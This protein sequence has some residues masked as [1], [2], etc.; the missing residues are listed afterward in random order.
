M[1]LPLRFANGDAPIQLK[2]KGVF[3]ETAQNLR[4]VIVF[5]YSDKAVFVFIQTE[6]K[7][8]KEINFRVPAFVACVPFEVVP[9]P[10]LRAAF[11]IRIV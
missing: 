5:T 8:L 11:R 2:V 9:F 10:N 4:I 1:G 3:I 6:Q 7:L